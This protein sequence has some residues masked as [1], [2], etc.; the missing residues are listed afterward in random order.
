MSQ[1]DREPQN[2]FG[3]VGERTIVELLRGAQQRPLS[4]IQL[5]CFTHS[6]RF[7]GESQVWVPP[8]VVSASKRLFSQNLSLS[9]FTFGKD[10]TCGNVSELMTVFRVTRSSKWQ[11]QDK[12][13]GGS[14]S[15]RI[16][17]VCIVQGSQPLNRRP[18]W[19]GQMCHGVTADCEFICIPMLFAD[20]IHNVHHLQNIT[21]K[22]DGRLCCD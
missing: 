4:P 14:V 7:S 21:L 6:H 19:G 5:F 20:S 3:T 8:D 11:Q 17:S 16:W 1:W 10:G 22:N 13:Y 18:S 2:L 12:N 9:L 15:E